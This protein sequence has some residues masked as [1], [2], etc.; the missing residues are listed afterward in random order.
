MRR[1]THLE[2]LEH[3]ATQLHYRA[4][5]Q[6]EREESVA[7]AWRGES[8]HTDRVRERARERKAKKGFESG[9]V[10]L[11]GVPSQP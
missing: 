7:A 1:Q 4:E 8:T 10:G 6:N 3:K 2:E 9:V 5:K 11:H